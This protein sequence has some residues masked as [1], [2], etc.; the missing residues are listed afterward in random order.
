MIFTNDWLKLNKT[1]SRSNITVKAK[2]TQEGRVELCFLVFKPFSKYK[3]ES[4][5]Q[6]QMV[7]VLCSLFAIFENN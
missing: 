7:R 4:S 6:V 5:D 3:A 1:L 2:T